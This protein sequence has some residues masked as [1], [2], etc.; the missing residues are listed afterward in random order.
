MELRNWQ[1]RLRKKHL[2]GVERYNPSVT[3][4]PEL[5]RL[6]FWRARLPTPGTGLEVHLPDPLQNPGQTEHELCDSAQLT[7]KD[8]SQMQLSHLLRAVPNGHTFSRAVRRIAATA[9]GTLRPASSNDDAKLLKR[10]VV[11]HSRLL[12]LTAAA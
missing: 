6:A 3:T 8:W 9:Q 10:S 5:T 4:P 7:T 12:F 1:P 2:L 11:L